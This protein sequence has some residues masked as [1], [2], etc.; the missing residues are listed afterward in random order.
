MQHEQTLNIQQKYSCQENIGMGTL[1]KEKVLSQIE[2]VRLVNKASIFIQTEFKASSQKEL[3]M[4]LSRP[5][6]SSNRN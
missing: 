1:A 5:K 4:K 2:N 3:I 6:E